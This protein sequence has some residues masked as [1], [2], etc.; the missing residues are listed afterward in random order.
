MK[1]MKHIVCVTLSPPALCAVLCRTFPPTRKMAPKKRGRMSGWKKAAEKL[2]QS[3]AA[4]RK[5]VHA[6]SYP[7]LK[8]IRI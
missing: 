3:N 5:I 8:S 6:N 7:K 4:K 2:S 1:H